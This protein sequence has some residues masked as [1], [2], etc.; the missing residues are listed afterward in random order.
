MALPA[1]VWRN[2]KPINRRRLWN[3]ARRD[4]MSSLYVVVRSGERASVWEGLPNLEL[5][6]GGI[7]Y[8]RGA[9]RQHAQARL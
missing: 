5:L 8:V 6:E 3:C 7:Q 2:P 4:E 9:Q 1:I